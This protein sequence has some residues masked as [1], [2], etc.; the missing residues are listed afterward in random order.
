MIKKGDNTECRNY[1]RDYKRIS[2]QFCLGKGTLDQIH[3]IRHIMD[4]HPE[5]NKEV[6]ILFIDFH[7]AFDSVNREKLYQSMIHFSIPNK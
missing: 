4:K 6:H 5:F 2:M 1:Q 7:Q 3:T